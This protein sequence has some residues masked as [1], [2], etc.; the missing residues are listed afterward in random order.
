M[1]VQVAEGQL[2]LRQDQVKIRQILTNLISNAI[3]FTPEGGRITITATKDELDNLMLTVQDTGVGISD[4]E[5]EIIFEKFRQGTAAIGADQ[6]TREHSGTGLGL[7]L[8]YDIVVKG[9]GGTLEVE[10]TAGTGTT[11]IVR[12]PA[13]TSA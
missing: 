7:S 3:K 1:Q 5:R 11:F 13:Q 9:H 6:L 8:A 12:L 2:P 4:D 10:S